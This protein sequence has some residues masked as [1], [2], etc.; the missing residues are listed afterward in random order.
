LAT[1]PDYQRQGVAGALLQ[2]GIDKAVSEKL[3][4]LIESV[5]QAKQVYASKGLIHQG[6][7]TLDY[8]V[9]D[10]QGKLTG[11]TRTLVLHNMIKE[12]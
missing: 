9:K 6:D 7:F 11:E 1:H 5:P 12:L 4:L 10:Q 3:P 8:A 2:W